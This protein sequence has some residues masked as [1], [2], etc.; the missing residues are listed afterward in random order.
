MNLFN[1][2]AIAVSPES[3]DRGALVAWNDRILSAF[4]VR[5][6]HAN[7]PDAFLTPEQG[8]LG[9]SIAGMP[10]YFFD[11]AYPTGRK[12]FDVSKTDVLPNVA[13]LTIYRELTRTLV[14]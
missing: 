1:A 9:V 14:M 12:Y 4:Y 13:V 11:K 2:V 3:R 8:S 5:K 10:Y 6:M 7:N